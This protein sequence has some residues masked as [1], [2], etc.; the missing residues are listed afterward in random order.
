LKVSDPAIK[1][2]VIFKAKSKKAEKPALIM[3][4]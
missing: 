3:V 1:I 2:S 4:K